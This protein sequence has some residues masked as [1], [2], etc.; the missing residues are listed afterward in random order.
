MKILLIDGNNIAHMGHGSN[1]MSHEGVRT[2]VVFLGLN[3][4]K[5]YLQRFEPDRVAVVWDGGKDKRRLEMFPE[6][7]KRKEKTELEEME[8]KIFF[9]QMDILRTALVHL[10]VTSFKVPYMEADDVIFNLMEQVHSVAGEL[11]P[12]FIVVSTDKDFYQLFSW[13]ENV[14]IFNPV[15]KKVWTKEVLT[16]ELGF[17]ANIYIDYKSMIGDP[18]DNLPGVK[19]IGP[20]TALEII[21]ILFTNKVDFDE[22]LTHKQKK[23]LDKFEKGIQEYN[24]MREL[25]QFLDIDYKLIRA[26]KLKEEL[27]PN[28]LHK[29]AMEI[30]TFLGFERLLKRFTDFV[31]PFELLLVKERRNEDMGKS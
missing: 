18:S 12:E 15:K 2:E 9:E 14:K 4:I 11:N 6:Y 29:N 21:N 8:M 13:F 5:G 22:E 26:S 1:V 31:A 25:I 23:A 16:E 30:L 7:K 17:S 3:M 19:G 28:D 24:R 20:K 27:T 10:G